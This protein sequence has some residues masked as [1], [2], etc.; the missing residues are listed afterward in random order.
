ME[1]T[2]GSYASQGQT[3]FRIVDIQHPYLKLSLAERYADAIQPGQTVRF[4]YHPVESPPFEA[5]VRSTCFEI[6]E[7]T[8]SLEVTADIVNLPDH[9]LP[10]RRVYAAIETGQDSA[11]VLPSTAVILTTSGSYVV[12]MKDRTLTRVRI[13]TG[14][15]QSGWTEVLPKD[16]NLPGM[17]FVVA[18]AEWLNQWIGPF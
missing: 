14:Q 2:Q 1:L 16:E 18:G 9:P 17:D 11:W 4:S 3:L 6:D 8:G 12:M 5:E 7:G 13:E 10:G 15:A